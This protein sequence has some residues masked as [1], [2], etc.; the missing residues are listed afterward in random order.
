M[1]QKEINTDTLRE[2][3]DKGEKVNILDVRPLHEREE[4][5]IPGS[6][7]IKVYGEL[8]K[9]NPNALKSVT[10]DKAVPVVTV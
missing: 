8:K 6:I 4:W 7:H 3:L 2:W 9:N 1:E 10:L 5:K